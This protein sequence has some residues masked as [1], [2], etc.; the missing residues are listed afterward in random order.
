MPDQAHCLITGTG[1]AHISSAQARDAIR[2]GQSKAK[3]E[4]AI[5]MKMFRLGIEGGRPQ[6]SQ[7]RG[8]AEVGLRGQQQHR[9]GAGPAASDAGL[10]LDSSEEA[11]IAMLYLVDDGG[12]SRG[13]VAMRSATDPRTTCWSARTTV[14]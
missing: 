14:P 3:A 13:P 5:Q 12:T 10:G 2:Q 6:G 1:L 11:E 8:P 9:R 4:L 7:P